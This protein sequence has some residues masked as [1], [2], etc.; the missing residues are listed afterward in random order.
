MMGRI[1]AMIDQVGMVYLRALFW[2]MRDETE[3]DD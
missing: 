1:V 3:E 2:Y